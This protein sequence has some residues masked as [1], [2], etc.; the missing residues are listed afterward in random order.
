[1]NLLDE[2]T[3]ESQVRSLRAHRVACRMIG[4]DAPEPMVMVVHE[5]RVRWLHEECARHAWARV[6]AAN[7]AA[8]AAAASS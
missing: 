3:P 7:L 2:N 6:R 8:A 5:R 1:M 4:V